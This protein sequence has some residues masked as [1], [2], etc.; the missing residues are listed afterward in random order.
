M[1]VHKRAVRLFVNAG[2]VYPL[3][4]ENNGLIDFDKSRW[5]INTLK[6]AITCK[7]CINKME[8]GKYS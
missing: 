7:H 5:N 8:R 3:C 4:Q 1:K 2:V 6:E